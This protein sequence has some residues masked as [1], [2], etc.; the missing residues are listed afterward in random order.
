MDAGKSDSA[1][2]NSLL[3]HAERVDIPHPSDPGRRVVGFSYLEAQAG[4]AEALR[5]LNEIAKRA[6]T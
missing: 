5:A 4:L 3:R 1:F 2:A 6:S